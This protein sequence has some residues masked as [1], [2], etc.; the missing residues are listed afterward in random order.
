MAGSAFGLRAGGLLQDDDSIKRTNQSQLLLRLLCKT[1]LMSADHQ[2][3]HIL[4]LLPLCSLQGLHSKLFEFG[5]VPHASSQI[6]RSSPVNMQLSKQ[7]LPRRLDGSTVAPSACECCT[8]ERA[9]CS[10][11]SQE[12]L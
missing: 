6:C 2:H 10:T 4:Y 3:V 1:V 7:M 9:C 5:T 12:V 11:T 8:L